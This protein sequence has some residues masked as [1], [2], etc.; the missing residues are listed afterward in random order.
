MGMGIAV[1]GLGLMSAHPIALWSL[2]TLFGVVHLRS[3]F[4][5]TVVCI[6][7]LVLAY[8]TNPTES[9]FR[10]FLTELSFRQH[11]TRLDDDHTSEAQSLFAISRRGT[12]S[13]QKH[14][15]P[16][17]SRSSPFHFTNRAAVSVRTPKHIFRSFGVLT[18]AAVVPSPRHRP[19]PT[20]TC[21][22]ADLDDSSIVCDSWFIGAFG[23]WWWAA[24]VDRWWNPSIVGAKDEEGMA[25]G[26]L[27]IKSLDRL[28]SFSSLPPS[29]HNAPRLRSRDK[30]GLQNGHGP[31]NSSPPPLPKSASLPLHSKRL[32]DSNQCFQLPPL[33]SESRAVPVAVTPLSRSPSTLF[34][35]S[36]AIAEV[37]R[38]VNASQATVNDLRTQ[39]SDFHASSTAAHAHL[40]NDLQAQ[41]TRKRADDS[42]RAELKGRTK[43]LEDAKRAAETGRRD[44][45]KRLRAAQGAQER[46]QDRIE[47]LGQD[48]E[49]LKRR[50]LDDEASVVSADIE[51][52]RQ[53]EEIGEEVER[54]K[55]EIKVA[56]EVVAGLAQRARELEE[57]IATETARLKK[58][59]EEAEMRR[60]DRSFSP[61]HVIAPASIHPWQPMSMAAQNPFGPLE[62]HQQQSHAATV[63]QQP[64]LERSDVFPPAIVEPTA[65]Q[66]PRPR[67]LSLTSISSFNRSPEVK[68]INGT[69]TRSK[70][71]SIFDKDIASLNAHNANGRPSSGFAP[72]G[73][74]DVQ[75]VQVP[76]TLHGGPLSPMTSSLIP[77]S[78]ISS[79]DI[80]NSDN[81]NPSHGNNVTGPL[82]PE[83]D[84]IIS[85]DWLHAERHS[86]MHTPASLSPVSPAGSLPTEYDPFEVQI[87]PHL[88]ERQS[89]ARMDT[90]RATLALRPVI[91]D[92][93]VPRSPETIEATNSMSN[94]AD[95]GVKM[96]PRRWFSKEKKGLNPDAKE[97]SLPKDRQ[98]RALSFLA[99]RPRATATTQP[100]THQTQTQTPRLGAGIT[101][102]TSSFFSSARAFAPSPAE[103]EALTRALGGSSNG[104]LER[105][106]SLSDVG[107]HPASPNLVHAP[108]HSTHAHPHAHAHGLNGVNGHNGHVLAHRPPPAWPLGLNTKFSPFADDEPPLTAMAGN[109]EGR[110]GRADEE[111]S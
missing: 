59:Q 31:R 87:H 37:L 92:P 7:L 10:A 52:Q 77:K 67:K 91:S 82:K 34:D 3:I 12:S 94:G 47:R 56:E 89:F 83:Q 74:Q 16:D 54:R 21:S 71:Y 55:K 103:R 63:Q 98:A 23:R 49:A 30:S 46:A 88:R 6:V 57:T 41:R 73:E 58:A 17:Y 26:V 110:K 19:R 4:F 85:R 62:Q 51:S 5:A 95:D 105:I 35:Q 81:G 90:Q 36:P 79:L 40:T 38:Q 107:S 27:D 99:H 111:R 78:L 104:S 70:G 68:L 8:L 24:R 60:Q 42:S 72:F 97:F 102:F 1:G 108:A 44:A 14:R 22:G 93:T 96:A 100:N 25:S 69:G 32:P 84:E 61:M 28:D 48:I 11:L 15:P 13:H 53:E 65:T 76:Q 18:V 75:H 109:G 9:S 101:S 66:S 64:P 43:A 80:D 39:L 106:P 86:A 33:A 45:E 2:R 50:M 20:S 29:P